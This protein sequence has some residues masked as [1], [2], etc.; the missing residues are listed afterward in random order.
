MMILNLFIYKILNK[1][2]ILKRMFYRNGYTFRLKNELFLY[3][4]EKTVSS[5]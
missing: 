1:T 5:N 3:N 4:P 2:M